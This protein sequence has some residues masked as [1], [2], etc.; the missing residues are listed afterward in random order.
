[1]VP[2][3]PAEILPRS[4]LD[5]AHEDP[6]KSLLRGERN[7]LHRILYLG[8]THQVA[9]QEAGA[10]LGDPAAPIAN[11]KGSWVILNLDV[12]LDQIV[13]LCHPMHQRILRTNASELT[14]NWRNATG[15]APTQRL[16][17]ALF[18]QPGLEGFLY[19]SS[20]VDARCLLVF[21][22]KLGPRSLNRFENELAR[23]ERIEVL[24]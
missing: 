10:L 18:E 12:V 3:D 14:G 21:P 17:Q 20:R 22:D 11:P 4:P 2:R 23:P 16:G 7:P 1:V 5:R 6:G 19:P 13:D 15:P 8:E 9:I 24:R